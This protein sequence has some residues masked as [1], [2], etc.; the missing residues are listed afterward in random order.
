MHLREKAAVF[1]EVVKVIFAPPELTSELLSIWAVIGNVNLVSERTSRCKKKSV[2]HDR[3]PLNRQVFLLRN[4]R[5]LQMSLTRMT[6]GKRL[7]RSILC[8]RRKSPI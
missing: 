5:R 6:L 8:S 2:S 7:H 1:P 4:D 3:I